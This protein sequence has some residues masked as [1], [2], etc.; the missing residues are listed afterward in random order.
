MINTAKNQFSE[1]GFLYLLWGWVV[2][3]CSIGH[4]I[5]LNVVKYE[6]HYMIWLLTWAA[7]IF[8]MFYLRKKS[9]E[10]KVKTYAEDI[11]KY[12]WITFVILMF[13][14]GVI[15][16]ILMGKDYYKHMYPLFLVLYGMPTFLSGIILR[17]KPLV[18]GGIACWVLAVPAS[19]LSYDYQLLVLALSVAIAWIVPGYL[20]QKKYKKENG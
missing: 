8:Q 9:K 3:I 14:V 1:N 5:L 19:Q 10:A 13:L 2:F 6:Y 15:L 12:V 16:G 20:L 11:V 17:F 7:V 18:V 4:F